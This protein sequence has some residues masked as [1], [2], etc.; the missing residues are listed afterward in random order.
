MTGSLTLSS[1]V[2]DLWNVFTPKPAAVPAAATRQLVF[3]RAD[4]LPTGL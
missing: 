2:F 4:V 3:V 1:G